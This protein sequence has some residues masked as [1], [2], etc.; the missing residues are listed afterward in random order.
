M[1]D[2]LLGNAADHDVGETGTA[3]GRHDDGVHAAS[4][5]DD[6][7]I[8]IAD[9]DLAHDAGRLLRRQGLSYRTIELPLRTGHQLG[10]RLR[11]VDELEGV[12][13]PRPAAQLAQVDCGGSEPHLRRR[14]ARTVLTCV[15]L[16]L[17]TFIVLSFTLAGTVQ[18][19]L[20][21][22][23]GLDFMVVRDQYLRF[24]MFWVWFFGLVMF[25]PGVDRRTVSS[26]WTP[27][28]RVLEIT[29]DEII[30][31]LSLAHAMAKELRP[32]AERLITLARRGDLHARRLVERRI[33]DREVL[34]RLFKEIGPR[35]AARP[36]GYTRILKLGSR[37][38][39]GA[40]L[41]RIELLSE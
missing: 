29:E 10:R 34:G 36:G 33:Q 26:L 12:R 8:R 6:A 15:T 28:T 2:H 23:I 3:S 37:P 14:R 38:V 24:W 39:D 21:R 27:T 9:H 32:Y 22:L 40:D 20:H 35:F 31:D 5:I 11:V 30:P 25:L 16:V 19:Y 7:L 4:G 18:T 17:L 1:S 41:A 13:K